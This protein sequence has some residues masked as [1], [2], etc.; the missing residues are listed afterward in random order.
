MDEKIIPMKIK[1]DKLQNQGDNVHTHWKSRFEPEPIRKTL[2]LRVIL[3]NNMAFNSYGL[4]KGIHGH[5]AQ[6]QNLL[7][8]KPN[9][10]IVTK[11]CETMCDDIQTIVE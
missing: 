5:S 4:I 1:I 9:D 3:S 11:M 7:Q 6:F 10:C 2:K 8:I